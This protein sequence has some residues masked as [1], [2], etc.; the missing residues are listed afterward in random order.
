MLPTVGAEIQKKCPAVIVN[1]DKLG[2]LPF[3]VIVPITDWK[4]R[5]AVAVWMVKLVPDGDNLLSKPSSAN[6]FQVRSVSTDRFIKKI[7]VVGDEIMQEIETALAK[8]LKIS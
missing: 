2:L 7:G 1:D 3:Q 6:C 5:Y 8:V 4:D